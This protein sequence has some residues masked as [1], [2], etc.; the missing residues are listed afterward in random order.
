MKVVKRS[1]KHGTEPT[2]Q[3]KKARWKERAKEKH[4]ED[5]ERRGTDRKGG[6]MNG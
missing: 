2:R 6:E 4:F 1:G 5:V 3:K